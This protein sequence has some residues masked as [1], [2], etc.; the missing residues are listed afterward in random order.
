MID[1]SQ[2]TPEGE[3]PVTEEQFKRFGEALM[4]VSKDE[5]AEVVAAEEREKADH[6]HEKRR[7]RPQKQANDD[8]SGK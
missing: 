5:L 6:P 4:Q 7:G 2:M 8:T 1:S 3:K